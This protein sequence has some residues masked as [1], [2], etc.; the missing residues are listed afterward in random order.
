MM[1]LKSYLFEFDEAVI[2]IDK[3]EHRK[4]LLKQ[5][6]GASFALCSSFVQ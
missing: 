2:D 4:P 5:D 6:L 1:V 3:T